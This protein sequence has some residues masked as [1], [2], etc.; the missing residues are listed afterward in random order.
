MSSAS[1]KPAL[2]LAANLKQSVQE[3]IKPPSETG[4]SDDGPVVY[5]ALVRDTRQYIEKIAHQINGCY[6]NAWYDACAVMIR[7]LL[8]TLII[9]CYEHHSIQQK[10]KGPDG[11]Y[12]YLKDLI[13]LVCAESSWTLGRNVKKG[14]PKLKEVGDKSAHSRRFNAHREDID[15]LQGDLRD[16][17]QEL[18]SIANLKRTKP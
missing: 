13:D 4:R 10:I 8:E 1:F 6:A 16:A 9:E 7:R 14:L 15:R 12:L 5:L 3:I 2:E 11:D 18:V 17:I